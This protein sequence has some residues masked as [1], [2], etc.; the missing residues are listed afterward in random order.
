MPDIVIVGSIDFEA[1][2]RDRWL[3]HTPKLIDE[4]LKEPGCRHYSVIADRMSLT[5]VQVTEIFDG[6]ESFERHITSHHHSE[7]ARLT[8]ACRVAQ[9]S[10]RWYEA[11]EIEP[12][13]MHQSRP[14][15]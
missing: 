15:Q 9:R 7:F 13:H 1:D 8:A 2:D 14:K 4:T 12:L 3:A 10:V 5:R 11:A 6:R